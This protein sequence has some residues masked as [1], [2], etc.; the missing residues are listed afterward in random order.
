METPLPVQSP[1]PGGAR[2]GLHDSRDGAYTFA[3]EIRMKKER[4]PRYFVTVFST[5]LLSF[6]SIA[7]VLLLALYAIY[8]LD[9]DA[10]AMR[11]FKDERA[12]A[13]THARVMYAKIATIGH[14]VSSDTR[15]RRWILE[16]PGYDGII[17]LQQ[18]LGSFQSVITADED[19][20]S[21]WARKNTT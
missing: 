7:L 15:L 2:I 16:V 8:K 4:S 17:A 10:K 5:A 13:V 6:T 19:I 20:L 12:Y 18:L 1:I 11:A 21:M 14:Q 3:L 9:I